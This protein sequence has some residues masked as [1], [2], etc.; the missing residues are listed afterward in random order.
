MKITEL[1]NAVDFVDDPLKDILHS[2][3]GTNFLVES[4]LNNR[5]VFE[6]MMK[7]HPAESGI[8]LKKIMYEDSENENGLLEQA[9]AIIKK[10]PPYENL[11]DKS[12][13]L[14]SVSKIIAL[15][16]AAGI[17]YSTIVNNDTTLLLSQA[18]VI[19]VLYTLK[20]ASDYAAQAE[21]KLFTE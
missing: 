19:P 11:F 7:K 3:E 8:A 21:F 13:K 12:K 15:G 18:C 20:K 14:V 9:E 10:F 2:D 6:K 4:F 1:R 17:V 5:T 16:G